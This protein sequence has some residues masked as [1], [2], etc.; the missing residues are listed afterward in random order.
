MTFEIKQSTATTVLIGPF[1]DATDG[2]TP[3]TGLAGAMTVNL[4]KNGAAQAARNSSTAITHDA[5]GYYRVHLDATDTNTAGNLKLI[6]TN[7]ATHLPVFENFRV[8]TAN[9]YDS[10]V[11]GTDALQVDAVEISSSTTAANNLEANIGNL[12]AAVS[13]AATQAEVA[14]E[15]SDAL[16]TDTISELGSIPGASP[17]F[18]QAIML[19]YMALRNQATASTTQS[20]IKNNAGT[21][22]GTATL[23][24]SSGT[25]TK[26]KY[27]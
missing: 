7:A 27:S 2:A 11:A 5:G 19:M 18:A 21:T 3:E 16:N 14:T 9:N 10:L 4:S 13:G 26:G 12:D 20:T 6:V 15:I 25:F 1:V 22:I 24:D 8:R 23:S 17:T